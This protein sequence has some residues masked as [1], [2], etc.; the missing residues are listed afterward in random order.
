MT[1]TRHA[2]TDTASW[3]A[4]R[5]QDVTASEIGILFGDYPH[6]SKLTLFLEK[7]GEIELP[8]LEEEALKRG[9]WAEDMFPRAMWEQERF[10]LKRVD[11]YI[12]DENLRLGASPDFYAT[13]DVNT[14]L[15]IIETKSV[16]EHIFKTWDGELP[17]HYLLQH[18]CQYALEPDIK[19][20]GIAVMVFGAWG[21]L[22]LHWFPIER[23]ETVI[24]AIKGRVKSFWAEVARG[25]RPEAEYPRD[26][27]TIKLLY[28][29]DTG[30]VVDWSNNNRMTDVVMLR[31]AV[32]EEQKIL[33]DK[34]K[35]YDAEITYNI[36]DATEATLKDGY[37]VTWKLQTRK[38]FIMPESKV[39][40]L[41]VS[42]KKSK[43]NK[44]E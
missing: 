6:K 4:L 17:L 38:T 33:E 37:K 29:N 36:G 11:V 24:S 42:R 35:A 2:I 39:R 26:A 5:K 30:E 18:Q 9:R 23:N 12:R 15:G 25:L 44:D 43:E 40:V 14:E 13:S 28:P 19:W 32:K 41:R 22:T 7:N 34:L 27:E 31:H 8:P 3:L 21:T 1:I 20:G 16:S 10:E